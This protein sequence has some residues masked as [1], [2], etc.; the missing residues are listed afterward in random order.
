MGNN[1]SV[2]AKLPF[3]VFGD[4][5]PAVADLQTALGKLGFPISGEEMGSGFG[6]ETCNAVK[7]FKTKYNIP[8]F[9][10][11]VEKQT[12]DALNNYFAQRR[13]NASI[14]FPIYFGMQ[15]AEV[16]KLHA[17]LQALINLGDQN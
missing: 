11:L 3:L 4:N 15:S 5:L 6:N 10:C 1:E 2:P 12:A 13:V 8:S 14:G 7:N 9:T 17:G 16:R